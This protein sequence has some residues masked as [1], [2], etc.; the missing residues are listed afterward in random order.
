MHVLSNTIEDTILTQLLQK[1]P[2]STLELIGYVAKK[3]SCT[4][5]GF[6]RSLRKLRT[7][8]RI[9]VYQSMVS[10]NELWLRQMRTLINESKHTSILGDLSELKVG[11]KIT[12]S[13]KGLTSM[14]RIWSH[15]F[16]ILETRMPQ[17]Y[18]LFLFN[19]HNWSAILREENDRTHD[20]L[21]G[22]RGRKAYL[23]IGSTSKLDKEA[24]RNAEFKHI[25][26]SYNSKFRQEIYVAVIG[27]YVIELRFS[28]SSRAR[29][30]ELFSID[31]TLAH[32]KR[33]MRGLDKSIVSKMTIEKNLTKATEWERRLARE[34]YIPTH[35]Q[36][37][38]LN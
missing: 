20:I 23:V 10:I 22:K 7:E 26:V 16:S 14:D 32:A 17:K 34:F 18:P 35:A 15:I 25:E 29:L 11:E 1:G 30:K 38:S 13:L 3:R 36:S 27:E 31:T 24:T 5:Q 19:P 4:K 28:S 9:V 12:L 6:Y 2:T 21:L 33:E 37:S 8:E